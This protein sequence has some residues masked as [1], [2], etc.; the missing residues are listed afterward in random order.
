MVWESPCIPLD[1]GDKILGASK[2]KVPLIKGDL[3][4]FPRQKYATEE[5]SPCIPLNKGDKILYTPNEYMKKKVPLIKGD[6]GG[7]PRQRYAS[8][9][10]SPSIPLDKGDKILSTSNI[11][12]IFTIFAEHHFFKSTYRTMNLAPI[13]P[14]KSLN[15]AFRLLKPKRSDVELFKSS[16]VKMLGRIDEKESEEN[17]KIHLMQFLKEAHFG[18]DFLIATKGRTDFVVHSGKT[19]ASPSAVLFEVKRP[20]NKADMVSLKSL[21]AKAMHEIILYFLKE[22]VLL[23]NNALT[24]IIITNIYEWFIFDAGVFEKL[25]AKNKALVAEFQKWSDGQLISGNTDLFYNEIAKPFLDVVTEEIPFT[26]FD[27]RDLKKFAENENADD[28]NALIPLFKILSPTHLLKLP[29]TN[30][31]N[32]LNSD[33][34]RELLHIIGLEEVKDGSRKLIR[35][36]V[37]PDEGS[38]L[39]NTINILDTEVQLSRVPGVENFGETRAQQL[40]AIALELNITWINR[41]L[42]L[43][44]LE[45]QLIQ[46]H[47]G[48][49]SLAFLN[50]SKI[51]EYD[52]LN[53]LFFQVL[54]RREDERTGS[55]AA[56]F[57]N[58]PYLNS[59]LFEPTALEHATFR[60][61]GL[62]DALTLP[63]FKNSVL[64]KMPEYRRDAMHRVSTVG[65]SKGGDSLNSLHYLLAFLDAYDFAS[66]GSEDIQ[67]ESKTLIN[68]AVLGLIFE[69]INGYRDGSIF[70]PGFITMYMCRESIRAAV[71]QKFTEKYG[72]QCDT[73]D[74]LK[75]YLTDKRT[76]A[77]LEANEIVNSLRICD[78]AVGSGHFL[79]SA[80]NEIIAI[81]SEL[82]ILA[83]SGGVR[84]SGVEI[85]IENDELIVTDAATGN[86][87]RYDVASGAVSKESQR[88]QKTLFHE[89]Q[90]IIEN[91]LF[92]VDINPNSVKICRLRLWIEL[93][94]NA[95]YTE[96]SGFKNLE[97]LPNIDINIKCGNSLVSRFHLDA[98]L[99]RSFK[100]FRYSFKDYRALVHKYVHARDKDAKHELEDTIAAIKSQYGQELSTLDPRQKKYSELKGALLA[101]DTEVGFVEPTPKQ[102]KDLQKKREKLEA[103]FKKAEAEKLEIERADGIYRNAFEWRFEFPEVLGDD[104]SFKGFDV[105]VGNPPYVSFQSNLIEQKLLNHYTANYKTVFKIYDLFAL[106]IEKGISLLKDKSILTYICPSV[107]LMNDSFSKLRLHMIKEGKLLEIGNLGDGVFD[108]AVVPTGIFFFK[109]DTKS[110]L[111]NIQIINQNI[112]DIIKTSEIDY[113]DFISN[114]EAGFNL[115]MT[116]DL[117]KILKKVEK[118][119]LK[120]GEILDIKE[121]IKTGD[122]K[123]F[124]S[125]TQEND[126]WKPMVTGKDVGQYFLKQRKFLWYKPELL[127]R[128][129]KLELFNQPKLFIRRVGSTLTCCYD[130]QNLLSTHVLYIA[131]SLNRNFDLRFIEALINSK[132]LNFIYKTKF[133]FKGDVFPEIR[134]GNLRQLPIPEIPATEQEPFKKLVEEILAK[135][136]RGEET[137]ELERRI[138]AMVYALYGLTEEEI[139]V[140][141]KS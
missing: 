103:D 61:S 21:N 20:A 37:T 32:S 9:E 121:S 86:F 40:E 6:L 62:D 52:A 122:D 130:N 42:F 50:F 47:R 57:K 106:F 10:E 108:E 49:R 67:E 12:R 14:K 17:V 95:Y 36:K 123:K 80:L 64:K 28:D 25:F 60:I 116:G 11:S 91:C 44:L 104:G 7:F 115:T 120:I 41:I 113:A 137:L 46:Y 132:F 69:K 85:E 51:P 131:S 73:F 111:K 79:V 110:D 114:A 58:I 59:S 139:A 2:G 19:A 39:E 38:L 24:H 140:V 31:S 92:G 75:N 76:T 105:V 71:V 124:I 96:E 66:E 87:F 109:K 54:A 5:E 83:D 101:L 136:Q 117:Y 94:K 99:N 102:A 45:A 63:L 125:E 23:K 126:E 118:F 29:F 135:K 112:K 18:E 34:Y 26:H 27:I 74:D 22:R 90:R 97:T 3:G 33:F 72:W 128:P 43:K 48:D 138:D 81:K 16:L 134:I 55:I 88:V 8:Q 107:F 84:L 82:G 93:L 13:S 129:I 141:E 78:P 30:D 77:I 65:D 98:D 35:R 1:K 70:T 56:A 100:N 89:K 119:P 4:G 133:P 15:K 127:G 68:A 53:K